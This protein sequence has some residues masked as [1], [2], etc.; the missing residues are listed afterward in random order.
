[1]SEYDFAIMPGD[2]SKT[3]KAPSGPGL[4][5]RLGLNAKYFGSLVMQQAKGQLILDA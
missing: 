4:E 3:N 2:L 1:M 5:L